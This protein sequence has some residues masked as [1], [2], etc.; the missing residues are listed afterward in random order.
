MVQ[1][2]EDRTD[3]RTAPPLYDRC[4]MRDF[5]DDKVEVVLVNGRRALVSL[6]NIARIFFDFYVIIYC[7]IAVILYA[8]LPV[9]YK[10]DG[11]VGQS[12]HLGGV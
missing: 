3:D 12:V 6:Q 4:V 5:N 2:G 8:F 7:L 11:L 9:S 10:L 1:D